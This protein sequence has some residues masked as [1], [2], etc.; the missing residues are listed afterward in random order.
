MIKHNQDGAISGLGISLVLSIILLI[1][2]I[3]FG[4]WAFTSRQDYK[5]NSDAKAKVAANAAVKANSI[6]KDKQ[7]AEEAK[8]PLKDYHGPASFGGLTLS[9]PKTW[10]AYVDVADNDSGGGGNALVDG[11]FNPDVVPGI[12][13]KS[14]IFALRVQVQNTPYTQTL[15]QYEGQQKSGKLTASAY[16]LPKLPD[17]VGVK[18]V[19]ELSDE[20]NVTLIVLPL[21]SQTIKIW[22]EGDQYLNDFNNNILP[23]FTFVP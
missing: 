15:K 11:Y 12:N 8:K 20:S 17:I 16:A 13:D 3:G 23:N 14:S 2:A 7:F 19:G 9:Y 1:A 6:V 10:S 21:R 22:T 18:L 5:N 4:A